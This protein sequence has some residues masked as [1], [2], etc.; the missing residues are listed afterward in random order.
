MRK[1]LLLC[2]F[3]YVGT[4]YATTTNEIDSLLL[5][6]DQVIKK[7]P[8]YIIQKEHNINELKNQLRQ[9]SSNEKRFAILGKL[10]DEYH[11]YNADSSLFIAKTRYQLAVSMRVLQN[12]AL[13]ISGVIF[14][15]YRSDGGFPKSRL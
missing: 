2:F 8:M 1:I 6:L 13:I 11:S 12:S 14:L 9:S 15:R 4:S 5:Q 10:F 7:R 3:F